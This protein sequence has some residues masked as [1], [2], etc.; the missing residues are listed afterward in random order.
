MIQAVRAGFRPRTD[1]LDILQAK[2]GNPKP[3]LC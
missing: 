1:V 3:T 2:D